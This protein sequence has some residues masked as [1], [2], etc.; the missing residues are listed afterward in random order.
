MVNCGRFGAK[1][2]IIGGV[3]NSCKAVHSVEFL[4]VSKR[5]C[6]AAAALKEGRSNCGVC[7]VDDLCKIVVGGGVKY[8]DGA[9]TIELYDDHKDVW[10]LHSA[11]TVHEH[12]FPTI[13]SDPIN[14]NIIFVGGD[15]V[16]NAKASNLGFIEWTDLRMKRRKFF[17]ALHDDSIDR[18]WRFHKRSTNNKRTRRR[19]EDE[20]G[21]WESRAL[22]CL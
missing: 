21:Q 22:F 14:P 3:D 16:G 19:D 15:I 17:N 18:L 20:Q 5:E 6:S 1:I 12:S 9:R 10:S 13:W 2:G 11:N 4:D 7:F 8:G